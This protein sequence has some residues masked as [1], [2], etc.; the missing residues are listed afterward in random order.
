MIDQQQ[1]LTDGD[2]IEEHTA[3][4]VRKP[5]TTL[6]VD[7]SSQ[8]WIVRDPNGNFWALSQ[9]ADAWNQRQPFQPTEESTLEPVPGH[10][11][12]FLGVPR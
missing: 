4:M 3:L 10:Y 8:Q 2:A 11:K 12:H 1:R 7:R 6:M 9:S 5:M